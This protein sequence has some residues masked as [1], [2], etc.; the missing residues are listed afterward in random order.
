MKFVLEEHSNGRMFM[1]REHESDW[2]HTFAWGYADCEK[3]RKIQSRFNKQGAFITKERA[4]YISSRIRG[5]STI[6]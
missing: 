6:H 2:I 3:A 1:V 4:L 5:N